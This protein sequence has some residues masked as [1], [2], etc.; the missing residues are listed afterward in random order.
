MHWSHVY[1]MPNISL[2]FFNVYGLRSRTT[3]AYG[4]VFGVFLAQKLAKKPL[5][6]VGNG[7]QT[8]DFIHISDLV[9][10][11]YKASIKKNLKGKIFNLGSGKETSVNEIAKIIGGNKINV[12]KRPGEPERSMADISKIKKE[13]GWKPKISIKMGINELLRNINNW[14][15]APVWTPR[16]ISKATKTWFK[17]LKK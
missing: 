9:D 3:G 2:R 7:K 13:L 12:P 4:A 10:A 1:N 5:T 17:L 16:L 6:I 8:R 14:S 15:D 11:I